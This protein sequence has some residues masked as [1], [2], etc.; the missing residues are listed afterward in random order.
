MDLKEP[1]T[2]EFKPYTLT[3]C[4]DPVSWE[5]YYN[6]QRIEFV[7]EVDIHLDYNKRIEPDDIQLTFNHCALGLK[8]STS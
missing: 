1:V 8:E 3:I 5:L 2:Y 6:G 7:K 4:V